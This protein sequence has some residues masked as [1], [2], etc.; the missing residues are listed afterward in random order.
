MKTNRTL[1]LSVLLVL[2]LSLCPTQVFAGGMGFQNPLSIPVVVQGTSEIRGLLYRGPRLLVR[3][4]QTGYDPNVPAGVRLIVIIDANQPRRIL[5]R[6]QIRFTGQ[7]VF[8]RIQPNPRATPGNEV[9]LVPIQAPIP[10]PG[11]PGLN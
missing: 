3:P 2:L 5:F 6:Q 1:P 11:G 10:G 7:N 9:I 4:K 8:Y